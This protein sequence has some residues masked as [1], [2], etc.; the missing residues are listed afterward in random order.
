MDSLDCIAAGPSHLEDRSR[1]RVAKRGGDIENRL[2]LGE[3]LIWLGCS[4]GTRAFD[5]ATRPKDLARLKARSRQQKDLAF[6]NEVF[7]TQIGVGAHA[8][9]PGCALAELALRD[10]REAV[11]AA[12]G[13][14]R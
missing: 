11:A 6:V 2:P 4:D 8:A 12:D 7:V 1:L 14:F 10:G 5:R 9:G 13:V 3:A